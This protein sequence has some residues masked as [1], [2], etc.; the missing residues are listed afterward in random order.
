MKLFK[1][2]FLGYF[3]F[4]SHGFAQTGMNQ[5]MANDTIAIQKVLQDIMLKQGKV[6]RADYDKFW[7]KTGVSSK[8]DK[9]RV[10]ASAKN[11]F[12]LIQEY[13]KEIW[14]CAEKAWTSSKN[15]PCTKASQIMEKLK[16][17]SP[18]PEQEELYKLIE[19]NYADIL[20][21]AANKTPLQTAN[22]TTTTS[23][24]LESIRT[25]R[26]SIEDS[27]EKMNKVLSVEFVE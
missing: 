20:N 14:I 18:M 2:I 16:K 8:A 3:L 5:K 24:T 22:T 25:Y 11:N 27:L 17:L 23:L 26:K 10:I 12:V 7:E 4:C 9:E 13:T 6:T 15:L 1:I 19:K 21:S